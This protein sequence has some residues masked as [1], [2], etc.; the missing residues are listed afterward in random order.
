MTTPALTTP[1]H[2][3]PAPEVLERLGSGTGGLSEA[4]A[5]ARLTRFGRNVLPEGRRAGVVEIF[6]R[7][8]LN[9][10]VYLLLAA[11]VLSAW[12]GQYAD[13]GFIGAVLVAN[14]AIGSYQEWGA[15]TRS[16]ALARLVTSPIGVRREGLRR[17]LDGRDLAPGD[18]VEV[19]SGLRLPADVRLIEA[20]ELRMDES[21]LTGESTPIDKTAEALLAPGDGLA[22]RSTM[23]HAGSVVLIGRGLGVVTAT[24]AGTAVGQLAASMLA[25]P[26]PPPPLIVRM[27]RFTH[28]VAGAML[29]AITVTAAV[30][31]ARGG[32][33]AEV[34]VLAV[35]LA[36]SA[37]P[38]GL[39]VALTVALSISVSRM[40]ARNVIVRVLAA[41]DGLGA[42]TV[43]AT[44]KTGTLTRNEL[45]LRRLWLPGV[46]TVE[47]DDD[48][49]WPKGATAA[50][51]SAGWALARA[52]VL[53]S[54]ASLGSGGGREGAV[55]D[56][57]DIAFLDFARRLG[58]ERAALEASHAEAHALA[59]EPVRRFAASFRRGPEGLEVL[60]K[61]AAETIFAMCRPPGEE[62]AMAASALAAAE[63]AASELAG[64][65]LRV[66]AVAAGRAD[67][68]SAAALRDLRLLGLAGIIDPLRPEAA[69]AVKRCHEAGIGVCMITGDHP[70]TALAIARELDL[71]RTP[72]DVVTGSDLARLRG[73]ALDAAV[74]R[75]RV[76]A[77]IEPLQKLAIVES[78]RRQGE[79]VAVT[80]DGVNDAP[81]LKAADI[82]VAM[83]RGGTDVARDAADIVLADDNFASIVAGIEEGR[84]ARDNVRKVIALVI[85]TGAAEIMLFLLAVAAGLPPPLT[86]VQLLWLNLVTNGIQ[87]VAL[88]FE[89]GEPGVLA[90]KPRP[91][92][93][94]IFDR[95][96]IEQVV[97]AGLW[98]GAIGFGAYAWALHLGF[99]H[100]AAQNALLW[101]LISFENA[102]CFNCRSERRSVL[103]VPL[104]NN[105]FL[106]LGVIGAQ[107]V[108][109]AAM[110]TP[111]LN[112][113]LGISPLPAAEW[114]LLAALAATLLP[115]M[116]IYKMRLRGRS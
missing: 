48:G 95:V 54:E 59:Y 96:M 93:E 2:A 4:E 18:V 39:P 88:A 111:G 91:P 81:A 7:Q 24:G 1:W 43:I 94:A 45:T 67:G 10:F 20:R 107:A 12:L 61:G 82:G 64:G 57:V 98:M 32:A 46:G 83:G 16:R 33:W 21:Q 84:V 85:A 69:D 28:V 15:E 51:R 90:R 11:A 104:A 38:E 115:A 75:G 13:A 101:L 76:F 65:G 26:A 44:D 79:L 42:C 60:V 41:V 109:L 17:R 29:V 5:L 102:H 80:G 40:A 8:F 14:A 68:A 3:L 58:I 35:A 9:P 19:E 66:L 23:L 110:V 77:R 86:A 50:G 55:G 100:A 99:A 114:L 70:L 63:L 22:D 78:L 49:D 92:A 36:V 106:V 112:T 47:L 6:V 30:E 72:D 105:R 34:M 87:D 62:A 97:L 71:A 108:H 27:R 113:L 37:I 31:L 116:E 53:C 56:T 52:A 25:R 103:A 73:A 74:A 89:K